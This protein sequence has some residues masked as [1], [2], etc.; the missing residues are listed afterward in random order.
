MLASASLSVLFLTLDHSGLKGLL[1]VRR[2]NAKLT[3]EV[4]AVTGQ[5]KQAQTVLPPMERLVQG[6]EKQQTDTLKYACSSCLACVCLP[7]S[8]CL[9]CPCLSF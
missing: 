2:D 7:L 1:V 4:E 6:L 8:V 9:V 5:V 3:A